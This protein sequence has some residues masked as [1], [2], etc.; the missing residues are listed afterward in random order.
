MLTT[1][2]IP[3]HVLD[4]MLSFSAEPKSVLP[5]AILSHLLVEITSE[6]LRFVA[7]DSYVLGILHLTTKNT[8]GVDIAC[9]AP[10]S[11]ALPVHELQPILRDQQHPTL[12]LTFDGM[13]VIV[14]NA[15]GVSLSMTGRPAAEYPDYH[16]IIPRHA[17]STISGFSVDAALIAK[18]T[19]CARMLREAPRLSFSFHAETPLISVSLNNLPAFYGLIAP[20]RGQGP[21][22]LP[23][24]LA[25][26]VAPRRVH[27][28]V[29]DGLSGIET[30]GNTWAQ[31]TAEAL[32]ESVPGPCAI[33]GQ[34]ITMGWLCL[35]T[36]EA[37][38]NGHVTIPVATSATHAR[39]AFAV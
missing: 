28:C 16:R 36:G 33:C 24:W 14:S 25:P 32:G 38:C 21:I 39:A 27:L 26:S 7:T 19:A 13:R 30:N 11:M 20:C 37:V 1:V 12:H 6:S 15:S 18:F 8:Y 3:G 9:D 35:D 17:S 23:S 31:F 2:S 10:Q 29:C 22:A 4:A 34:V 5:H